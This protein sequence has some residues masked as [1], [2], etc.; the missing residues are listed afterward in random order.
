MSE[1]K[2]CTDSIDSRSSPQEFL[3]TVQVVFFPSI[4]KTHPLPC[5]KSSTHWTCPL[6]TSLTWADYT[7]LIYLVHSPQC[8]GSCRV[9][10]RNKHRRSRINTLLTDFHFPPEQNAIHWSPVYVKQILLCT[11]KS[12]SVNHFKCISFYLLYVDFIL[13]FFYYTFYY[14]NCNSSHL[15]SSFVF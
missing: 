4:L 7:F 3:H 11:K 9:Y 5:Q 13:Q 15:S 2:S 8:W 6:T 12:G 1:L 10:N 14:C